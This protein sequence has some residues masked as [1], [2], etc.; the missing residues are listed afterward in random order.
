MKKIVCQGT[1][2]FSESEEPFNRIRAMA[3]KPVLQESF[4]DG[5]NWVVNGS[6]E[7]VIEGEYQQDKLD[8][9]DDSEGL[10]PE[11]EAE[12]FVTC[13]E[14]G[15]AWQIEVE[16]KGRKEEPEIDIKIRSHEAWLVAE[17]IEWQV[18][19]E[20]TVTWPEITTDDAEP[21]KVELEELTEVA[22]WLKEWI[23]VKPCAAPIPDSTL[24][25][26]NENPLP[27]AEPEVKAV[28]TAFISNQETTKIVNAGKSRRKVTMYFVKAGDSWE[29]IASQY[30][31]GVEILR[32][33]NPGCQLEAGAILWVPRG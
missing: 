30:G 13:L 22:P 12:P 32:Q 21:V 33:N 6:V 16:D 26:F 15:A 8:E 25:V 11:G 28:K 18:E 1:Y 23:E 20:L 19:M 31:V 9:V 10:L 14:T 17:G 4:R 27:P 29:K 3:V 2:H 7:V 5:N 24:P